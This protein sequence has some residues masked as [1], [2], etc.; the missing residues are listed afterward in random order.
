MS[1]FSLNEC[2]LAG[3]VSY[4]HIKESANGNKFATFGLVTSESR[5]KTDWEYEDVA[6]FHNCIA[7]WKMAEF[8]E[9]RYK[10]GNNV[11]LKGRIE[12]QEYEKDDVKKINTT[13]VVTQFVHIQ[14]KKS[15]SQ[16]SAQDVDETFNNIPY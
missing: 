11:L 9:K 7:F 14:D 10:K 15:E 5:K 8:F 4:H 16:I 6:Q 13:I 1:L 3:R 2:T 12:Y